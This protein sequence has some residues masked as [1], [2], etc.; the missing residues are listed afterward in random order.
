MKDI[1]VFFNKYKM[2]SSIWTILFFSFIFI[3]LYQFFLKLKNISSY[4]L[5]RWINREKSIIF[6]FRNYDD[7]C[8]EHIIHSIHFSEISSKE[9]NEKNIKKIKDKKIIVITENGTEILKPTR[10]LKKLIHKK[11]YVL[12]NGING[13]KKDHLPLVRKKKL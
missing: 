10:M 4:Q 2:I 5:I 13:W 6:D 12:T 3:N 11:I 1:I 7:F 8:K 9:V